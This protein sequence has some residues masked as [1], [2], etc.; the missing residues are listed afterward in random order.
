MGCTTQDPCC[1]AGEEGE[2]LAVLVDERHADEDG[3]SRLVR[4]SIGPLGLAGQPFLYPSLPPAITLPQHSCFLSLVRFQYE[5]SESPAA[6]HPRLHLLV[7]A[8]VQSPSS[9]S[10]PQPQEP[11]MPRSQHPTDLL[12]PERLEASE[13]RRSKVLDLRGRFCSREV[14]GKVAPRSLRRATGT[15]SGD[16][17]VADRISAAITVRLPIDKDDPS[18]R[19][20]RLFHGSRDL[21]FNP[22]TA[23]TLENQPVCTA[24]RSAIFC[25]MGRPRASQHRRLAELAIL[26]SSTVMAGNFWSTV[27]DSP[28]PKLTI[29]AQIQLYPRAIA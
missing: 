25:I 16:E 5:Q 2:R 4:C 28:I 1:C 8:S 14:G 27:D 13:S 3:T 18:C 10:P 26:T 11:Q 29:Q 6:N 7:P 9:P 12:H 17:F 22:R 20:E 24:A 19:P 15:H 21:R 23:S